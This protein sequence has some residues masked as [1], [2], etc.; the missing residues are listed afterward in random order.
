MPRPRSPSTCRASARPGAGAGRRRPRARAGRAGARARAGEPPTRAGWSSFW[1]A[2]AARVLGV[3]R[4]A[5]GRRRPGPPGRQ[6]EPGPRTAR[7]P[8]PTAGR[9]RRPRRR[10]CRARRP[11]RAA[12]REGKERL[13]SLA[14]EKAVSLIAI[15]AHD[16]PHVFKP[17]RPWPRPR[18]RSRRLAG[19][20]DWRTLPLVTIDPPDAKDHDDAVHAEPDPD[21]TT[22][23]ATSSRSRS[24]TSPPMCGRARRSTARRWTAAIRCIFPTA[25][26]RCCRSASPT[27]SARC[28]RTRTGR[29]G[30]PPRARRRRAQAPPHVPSR[31]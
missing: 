2:A 14:S 29:A 30:G 28:V 27:T 10:R 16:I 21:P 31:A 18:R 7:P 26:C 1:P 25:S 19:R 24:P 23:A 11:L 15:H 12:G 4:E 13:G 17:R 20:E 5:A 6:E 22:T 9:G 8:R 3:F